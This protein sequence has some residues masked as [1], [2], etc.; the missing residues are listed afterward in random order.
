MS[1]WSDSRRS[2]TRSSICVSRCSNIDIGM[3][4]AEIPIGGPGGGAND[5]PNGPSPGGVGGGP[6]ADAAAEPA[7]AAGAGADVLAERI[8]GPGGGADH[9][10]TGLSPG[11]V[12]GGLLADAAA[13]PD[14]A[15]GTAAD[16]AAEATAGAV[17]DD[18]AEA[19]P[20]PCAG[21]G[22]CGCCGR[23]RIVSCWLTRARSRCRLFSC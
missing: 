7:P 9:G 4:E 22:C 2:W 1:A 18:V 21:G 10:P 20:K 15:P 3:D 12:G 16:A 19:E 6:L 13:E 17:A 5:G 23:P 14:P 11:G 8:G